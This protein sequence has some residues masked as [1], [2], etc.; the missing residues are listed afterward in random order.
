MPSDCKALLAVRFSILLKAIAAEA[1]MSA[2]SILVMLLPV[3]F[4]SKVL[5][6]KVVVLLAFIGVSSFMVT[7]LDNANLS[8]ASITPAP[9]PVP[10]NIK[11]LVLPFGIATVAPDPC[12]TEID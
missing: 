7:L 3:P 6:V 9:E 1:L 12:L 11:T 2:F 8:K 4:A 10:S 5:L